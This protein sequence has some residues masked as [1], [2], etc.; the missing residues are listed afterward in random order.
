MQEDVAKQKKTDYNRFILLVIIFAII[1]LT[2][3]VN[4]ILG[5]D[6]VYTHFYYVPIILTGVWYYRKAVYLALFLGASHILIGFVLTGGIVPSTIVRALMFIVVAIVVAY[7]SETR[8]RLYNKIKSSESNLMAIFNSVYDA[9]IIHDAE[10]KIVDVNDRMLEM[11]RVTR[12]EARGLSIER[13]LSTPDNPIG[14]LPAIWEKALAGE[15]QLFEWKGRRPSDGVSFYAEVYLRRI[16]L[17]SRPFIMAT[18]RDIDKRKY[19]EEE[20]LKLARYIQRLLESTDEGI[21]GVDTEGFCTVINR[22]ALRMLGYTTEE[23]MGKNMHSLVHY[24]KRDGTPCLK[25]NCCVYQSVLTGEGCRVS[26]DVFWRK[27]G[28]CFPVEY[29]SYPIAE[30]SVIKGSVVTFTDITERI[31]AEQEVQDA[32]RQAELYVDLMGHDINNMNQIGIG[33]LEQ[34]LET[35]KISD[36]E[37]FF[38]TKPLEALYNSSRLIDNVRKLQAVQENIIPLKPVDVC[39]TLEDVIPH[40]THVPGRQVTIN[41]RASA[42]CTVMANDLLKDVFSNI[43]G[44]AVKH[45]K[46]PVTIDVGLERT[47]DD[48][49]SYCCV[50]VDDNGPGIPDDLKGRLFARFQRGNTKASGRGLGLYLVKSLVESYNG[51]VRVEDRITGDYAKGARFI[52]VLPAIEKEDDTTAAGEG[53]SYSPWPCG[54]WRSPGYLKSLSISRSRGVSG[55]KC[56]RHSFCSSSSMLMNTPCMISPGSSLRPSFDTNPYTLTFSRSVASNLLRKEAM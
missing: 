7:L 34:A 2:L 30:G 41:Y 25:E 27:D 46:G 14:T 13:D 48:G 54:L 18:I 1:V 51:R 28:T 56:S 21:V 55:R 45:S 38:I 12:N 9:I 23:I 15:D 36:D 39:Q 42:C 53:G 47:E 20:R 17:S 33:Y 50:T 19:A 40:F 3:Y 49:K 6:A 8:D 24:K 29:S 26:S 4:V 5:T 10:G 37:K 32:R 16:T 43:I 35:I 11:Y 22:S 52:V 44:N 31:R